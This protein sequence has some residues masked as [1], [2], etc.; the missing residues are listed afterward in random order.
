[1]SRIAITGGTGF[2]GQR[3]IPHLLSQGHQLRALTRKAQTDSENLEWIVGDLGDVTALQRLC[4]GSDM[5]IHLAGT[6]KGHSAADFQ[7]GNVAG[8]ANLLRAAG[9]ARVLHISSLAARQPQLSHYCQSKAEAEA[10]V[11]VS[12]ADW[13]ILRA[14]AVYGPGDR[15]TL[16]LFKAAKGP[17]MPIPAGKQQTSWIHV[18]DLC[19][20]LCAA[21]SPAVAHL[22]V[23]VDDGSGGYTHRQFAESIRVAVNGPAAIMALPKYILTPVGAMNQLFGRLSTTAP[24]LT[25]GKVREIYHDDWAVT[26]S[27]LQ[28]LT[29]WQPRIKVD[30]GLAA[31]SLWYQSHSWL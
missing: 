14:P 19:A 5:I 18:D 1:M 13:T 21:L 25:T 6:I 12:Q 3:L 17:L 23:E 15:E 29:Y 22:Q 26:D 11:R 24:M 27:R 16:R 28:Q 8:T 2:V 30:Q 9:S 31:T 7:R 10:L 20:A 4:Q